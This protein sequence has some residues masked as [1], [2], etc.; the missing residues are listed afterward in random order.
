L[1]VQKNTKKLS[2][3]DTKINDGLHVHAIVAMAPT[4]RSS[5]NGANLKN[6]IRQKRNRFIGDF[7]SIADIDVVRIKS[8]V[9]FVTDYVFKS[10][11]R[12]P[13]LWA[14]SFQAR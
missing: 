10:A 12:N 8:K 2:A 7:T 14:S 11:K 3:K 6:T 9:R 4:L 13:A 1:P 5:L